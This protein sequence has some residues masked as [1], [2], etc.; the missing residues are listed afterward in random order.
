MAR[1]DLAD[2]EWAIIAPLLP[3]QTRGPARKKDQKVLNGIFYILRTGGRGGTC[4]SAT[5]RTRPFITAMFDGAAAGCGRLC[6]S[7]FS[8]LIRV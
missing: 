5:G 4:P 6:P 7:P 8:L 1:F 2:S 3:K